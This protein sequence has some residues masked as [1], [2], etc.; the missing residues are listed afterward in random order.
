MRVGI[1]LR[2]TETATTPC[3]CRRA[4][5]VFAG[6]PEKLSCKT[7]IA[8]SVASEK[9]FE[10]LSHARASGHDGGQSMHD[11]PATGPGQEQRQRQSINDQNDVYEDDDRLL[12]SG[13]VAPDFTEI[14]RLRAVVAEAEETADS[15][16]P[17]YQYH[18]GINGYIL[19]HLFRIVKTQQARKNAAL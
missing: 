19:I 3:L 9:L 2:S 17:I 4:P 18:R 12:E 8:V 5:Q 16:E 15:F 1:S 6:G 10:A 14:D 13:W 7:K 11:S